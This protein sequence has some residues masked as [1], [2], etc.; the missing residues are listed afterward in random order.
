M[1]AVIKIENGEQ[2]YGFLKN[3]R[4]RSINAFIPP[5]SMWSIPAINLR[6]TV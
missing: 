5:F 4:I 6:S 3:M 1:V 2:T